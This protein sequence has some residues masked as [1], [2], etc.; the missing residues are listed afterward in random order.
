MFIKNNTKQHKDGYLDKTPIFQFLLL[1]M[2]F[3]LWAAAAALNDIL[4]TQFK[5]IFEL[6][7]FASALVQSAFYG[8]YFLIAIPASMVIK[9][10][11]YKLAI[12]IGLV[13]Y[14]GGCMMFYP[15]STAATYT[16]FLAAIFC[17][18]IGLS[19]LETSC[20]TYSS[21]IGEP[22]RA[23][24][25]L[26]ISQTF[27]ALGYIVGI[28]MGKYLVFQ[29][30]VNIG[31]VMQTLSGA[32]LELFKQQVLQHTLT[33]Y[34]WLVCVLVI[35]SILIAITEFPNCKPKAEGKTKQPSF[36]ETIKYLSTNKR[37]KNGIVAQFAYVGMQVA[38]WSFT[39]RLALEMGNMTE[40]D[41]ANYLAYAFVAYFIGKCV[42]N[43]LM[44]KISQEN[45]LLG[46]SV[47]GIACLLYVS[48]APDFSAVWV[49]VFVS[50]LFGPGWATIF[51]STL[52]SVD[53]KY[54]ETAGA[55]VVMAIIGGAVMPAIQGLLAD[56]VGM[57]QSFIV[58]V[59]CFGVIFS[60][61][62]TEKKHK[63]TLAL[64]RQHA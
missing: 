8:G 10:S 25:R 3:P 36:G 23:T 38:V 39:I 57:Q 5:S 18:A 19:F 45:V 4:I 13:L 43:Y 56:H 37:F 21:M 59:I 51:A 14:I 31:E 28:L 17:I 44:T 41:A 46:Y 2:V 22:Q 15:A 7:N 32:E 62:A 33:P 42:A 30:G 55:I 27:N 52:Q 49:A 54:T 40:R 63:A 53:T 11:S 12:L 64:A 26:N 50:A 35:I 1:S 9:K 20:N 24:L 29:E 60:Y 48:F 58:N 61:F 34:K 6:S 16:M 47:V